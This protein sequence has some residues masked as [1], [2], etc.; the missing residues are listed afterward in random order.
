[1][2]ELQ[3]YVVQ[4]PQVGAAIITAL[5][6]IVGIFINIFIN[7][8]FRN[9]DYKNKNRIQ[10]IENHESYYLPLLDKVERLEN[11]IIVIIETAGPD[12]DKIFRGQMKAEYVYNVKMF[13]DTLSDLRDFLNNETH[14]Y[15]DDY[16]LFKCYRAVKKRVEEFYIIMNNETVSTKENS[17]TEFRNEL[18]HLSYMILYSEATIMIDKLFPR[19]RECYRIRKKYH[20]K[21]SQ[22]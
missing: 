1:M 18:A 9:R 19:I 12:A 11:S 15:Q 6:G 13:K 10:K 7:I 5:C 8:R 20:I 22:L 14:K 17:L 4:N 16:K 2:K 21:K 3:E